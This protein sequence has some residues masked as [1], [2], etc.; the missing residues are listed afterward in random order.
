MIESYYGVKREIIKKTQPNE[1][2]TALYYLVRRRLNKKRNSEQVML[3]KDYIK[4]GQ[5]RNAS[6]RNRNSIYFDLEE[7]EPTQLSPVSRY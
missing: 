3:L 1:D 6:Y 4:N 7:P 2:I 5:K